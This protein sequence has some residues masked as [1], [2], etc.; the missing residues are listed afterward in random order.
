MSKQRKFN[1]RRFFDGFHGHEA[2][3][4]GLFSSF[5]CPIPE[6]FTTESVARMANENLG[7]ANPL[8]KLLYEMDDL[9]MPKGREIISATAASFAIPGV[10]PGTDVTNQ[11]A[12]LW[13]WNQ[14]KDAF[15]NAMDRLAAAG[16]QGGL[17]ALYPGRSARLIDDDVAAVAGF[18][19]QLNANIAS[20]NGAERFTI[21][22]YRDGQ[23]LVILVFCERNAEARLEMESASKAVKTSIGKPVKQDVLF[24][25]QST[26]ELEI[27]TSNA[28]QR[29]ILRSS[30]AVGVMGDD[31]FFEMEEST[32][33][34]NL[35]RL[36]AMDFKL[37][38]RCLHRAKITG[39]TLKEFV[40]TKPF[41]CNFRANRQDVIEFL[42][43]KSVAGLLE[44]ATICYVRIELIM[45]L[46]R[47]DRKSIELSGDN[48]IKFNRASHADEVY[49][50]LRHWGLMGIRRVEEQSAA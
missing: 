27:E 3:I 47:L 19:A 13:L 43:A 14:D 32:R 24:Y 2:E 48:R 37:P 49:R 33:V 42:R 8:T 7:I 38:V 50:Y 9:A 17:L 30:F 16:V 46:E 41:T 31:S 4:A 18:E 5:G 29:E 1:A 20:W 40:A 22:H 36:I 35:Q 26:G 44:R 28:K 6:P 11:R 15:E 10:P 12:V 45:G 23:M 39:L 21:H 25:D 34:L